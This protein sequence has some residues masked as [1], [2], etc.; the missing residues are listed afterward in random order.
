MKRN[1]SRMG[2]GPVALGGFIAFTLLVLFAFTYKRW[3]GRPP[4][5]AFDHEFSSLGR[6]PKLNLTVEDPETGLHH[7]SIRLKQEDQD[8]TLADES[9]D[10]KQT[11][12]SRTY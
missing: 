10:R 12:K 3:E 4:R 5:V 8:V 2:A 11:E 6:A 1:S 7:I 9:F